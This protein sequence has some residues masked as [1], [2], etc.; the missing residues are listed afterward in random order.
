MNPSPTGD[1]EN[2]ITPSDA[3]SESANASTAVP[4]E[5]GAPDRGRFTFVA[6]L[7]LIAIAFCVGLSYLLEKRWSRE[8]ATHVQTTAPAETLAHATG[9]LSADLF[10]VTEITPGS[11]P[12]ATINGK[13]L[14]EGES[15]SVQTPSGLT[16]VRLARIENGAVEL[17]D[18][19]QTI[20]ANVSPGVVQQ[21][22]P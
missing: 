18:G 9:P 21:A 19:T 1:Q 4:R 17:T 15:L 3:P 10:Q 5:N 14:S 6:S 8:R 20:V 7:L 12:T 13:R 22:S 11:P 2:P 16:N